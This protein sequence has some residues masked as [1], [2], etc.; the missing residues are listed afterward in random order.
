LTCDPSLSAALDTVKRL[1]ENNR[2]AP[3]TNFYYSFLRLWWIGNAG[4]FDFNSAKWRGC[5]LNL[6]FFSLSYLFMV[7][8]LKKLFGAENKGI[9][10]L[11]LA[12]AFF[13]TGAI[14]NTLFIRPY[15]LQETFFI[16][17]TLLFLE[18]L[19][20]LRSEASI[21]TPKNLLVC[22]SLI[23]LTLLTGYF[24]VI[25]VLLLWGTLIGIA[26]RGRKKKTGLFL[27]TTFAVGVLFALILYPDYLKGFFLTA[28]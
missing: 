26:F 5:A 12:A 16:L 28:V 23:A 2:D 22:G 15:A 4:H 24:A 7:M 19:R 11:G 13:N 10:I 1:R 9:I 14:S 17:I 25:Y 3:H 27:L 8:L 18:L 6:V 20:S 21:I